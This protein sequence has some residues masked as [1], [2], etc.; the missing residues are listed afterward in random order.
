MNRFRHSL[1][2]QAIRELLLSIR[3]D[4]KI[5]QADLSK[6]LKKPQSYISKY[7]NGEKNLDL[8]EILNILN[9]MDEDPE[10]FLKR[11]IERLKNLKYK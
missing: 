4:K 10:L 8:I 2:H 7:E 1:P 3:T 5:L 6:K 9:S 11:L